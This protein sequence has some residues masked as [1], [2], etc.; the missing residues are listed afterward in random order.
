M[1]IVIEGMEG[2]GKTTLAQGLEEALGI[3]H[4]RPLRPSGVGSHWDVVTDHVRLLQRF[5][6]PFN[7][8]AEDFFTADVLAHF[9]VSAILDRSMPSGVAYSMVPFKEASRALDWWEQRLVGCEPLCIQL[10]CSRSVCVERVKERAHERS[11]WLNIRDRLDK[12]WEHLKMPKV[13]LSTESAPASVTLERALEYVS[14][15]YARTTP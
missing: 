6:V 12:C 10:N 11:R 7:T 14:S 9:G 5:A 2:T 1:I 15:A 4:Y 3:Q 8:M 13:V